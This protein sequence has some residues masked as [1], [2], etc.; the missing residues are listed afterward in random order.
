MLDNPMLEVRDF[1]TNTFTHYIQNPWSIITLIVDIVIVAFLFYSMVKIL[2]GSRAMQL[3]KGIIFLI[4]ITWV[5]S[6]FNL[7][8][9]NYLLTTVMTYG[10]ILLIVLFQPELRRALE[11]LGSSNKLT[12]FFGFE[13]DIISKTKESE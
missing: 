3:V 2:K 4:L 11:Q 1:W 5:I 8:I 13:K 9:L 10:V 7:K 6:I 12:R